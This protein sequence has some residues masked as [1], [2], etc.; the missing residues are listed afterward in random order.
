MDR[1][2]DMKRCAVSGFAVHRDGA[3]MLLDNAVNDRESQPCPFP[4]F[5][6]GKKGGEEFRNVVRENT[7][8]RIGDRQMHV[9]VATTEPERKE[10]LPRASPEWH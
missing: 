2:V 8:S 7:A 9:I 1:Q 4:H 5:F 10:F 3:L 6:G